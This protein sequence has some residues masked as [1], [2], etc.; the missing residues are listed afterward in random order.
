ML[1]K[2][3]TDVVSIL[4]IHSEDSTRGSYI[5]VIKDYNLLYM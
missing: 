2:A 4:V 3:N 5:H 1:C